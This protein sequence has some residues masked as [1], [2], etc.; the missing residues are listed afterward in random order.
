MNPKRSRVEWGLLAESEL[1][2]VLKQGQKIDSLRKKVSTKFPWAVEVRLIGASAMRKLNGRYRG[3]DAPTDVL[4][5]PA[6]DVFRQQG[7]LGELLICLPVLK[8]QAQQL[9]HSEEVE[10]RV[11]LVHGVLHLLGYDHELGPRQAAV[12]KKWEGQLLGRLGGGRVAKRGLIERA[13]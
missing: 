9:G 7:V 10:L 13:G 2:R 1:I 4:S 12:M 3:K 6:P 5:F 8:K 11:L